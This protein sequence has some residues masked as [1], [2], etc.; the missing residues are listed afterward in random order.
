MILI[1]DSGV[2]HVAQ[3]IC[4]P[5]KENRAL[6]GLEGARL[7]GDKKGKRDSLRVENFHLILVNL[8]SGLCPFH[9]PSL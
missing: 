7:K 3:A 9:I 6:Q 8:N 5:Y 4:D 1:D 2:K